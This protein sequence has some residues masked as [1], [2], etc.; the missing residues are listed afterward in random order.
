MLDLAGSFG[1]N[2][3]TT[4]GESAQPRQVDVSSLTTSQGPIRFSDF[5]VDFRSGELRKHGARI[6]LQ[7]QPFQVLHFLLEHPGEL[8]TREEL[9]K[10]IW[11]VDTFVDFDHGLNNAVKKLREALGDDADKPRFIETLS[12]RGYRFI[13]TIQDGAPVAA[14]RDAAVLGAPAETTAQEPNRKGVLWAP[15]LG[16]AVVVVLALL[17]GLNTGGMRDRLLGKSTAPRIQSLA[18]IP[19]QNLSNDPAQ[20]YF[21]DGMTDALIT[22][23]AQIGSLKVISRTSSMQYKQTKKSLPEIAR[24]LHVDGIIEGTVQRSGDR[25]RITAQLIHGTTDKHLWA[26]S[27]ERELSDV[28]ALERDVANDIAREV[29]TKVVPEKQAG[30]PQPRPVHPKVVEAYIQGAYYLNGR[31]R[32]WGDAERKKARVYFQ[33]A[34][35]LDPNFAPAYV[36]LAQSH[37]LLSQGEPED[38]VIARRAAEKAAALD[39]SSS[40]ARVQ[41]AQAKWQAWDW[42]GTEDD[43]R[44]AIALN[45]N[46]AEGHDYLGSALD[47][48]G[49]SEEAWREYLLA[50]ELDPNHDH[51]ADPLYVRG[52][53]DRAIEIRQRI[54]LQ[55]PSDGYNCYALALNYGQKGMYREFVAELS[56]AA[57][58]FEVPELGEGL[59]RAYDLSGQRGVLKQLTRNLEHLAATKQ[60]YMPGAMAQFYATLGDNDRAFY[61][62]GEYLKHHDLALADPTI[63]FKTDPWFAPLRSDP[64]FSEFLRLA[65]LPP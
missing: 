23:L 55:D 18:V 21:S 16:L 26:N 49:R 37:D 29:H 14:Q 42:A 45:P 43:A 3:R 15:A 32:G 38:L 6:K 33:R 65:G 20:E 36:G 52:Q 10:R 5:Q 64:R 46:D 34:I 4:A 22:D 27:Y 53:F 40:A 61:W 13:G 47:V 48:M 19:L 25:V 41:I 44:R 31:G 8:V 30:R 39:P 62:L 35:D 1:Q 11:P 50:Q 2:E 28:F 63:F 9:Q 60:L 7:V 56:R 51:L 58:L 59:Q 54:A 57:A 17:F 24:E 12:K